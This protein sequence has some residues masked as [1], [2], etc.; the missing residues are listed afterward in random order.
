MEDEQLNVEARIM[1]LYVAASSGDDN[2]LRQLLDT[3]LF[4]FNGQIPGGKTSLIVAAMKGNVNCVKI[5]L[6]VGADFRIMNNYKTAIQFA[7]DYGHTSCIDVIN[8]HI[9]KNAS[10]PTKS[11][12]PKT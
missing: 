12:G 5:L 3:G 9:S 10:K 7:A 6:E 1:T 2:Y 8:D 11:A 4:D